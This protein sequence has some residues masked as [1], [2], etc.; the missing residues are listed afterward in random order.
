LI[1]HLF[2]NQEAEGL[3]GISACETVDAEVFAIIVGEALEEQAA[4]GRQARGAALEGEPLGGVGGEVWPTILLENLQ[5]PVGEDGG[6]GE[7]GA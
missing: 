6:G 7:F 2:C 1:L 3:L 4:L 5:D